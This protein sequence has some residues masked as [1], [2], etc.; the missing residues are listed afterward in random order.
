MII[1]FSITPYQYTYLNFLNGKTETR[2]KKFENDYWG[3]SIKE[4]IKY[5]NFE[6]DKITYLSTCGVNP[7]VA[8]NYF[9]KKGYFNLEFLSPEESD[10]IIMTNRVTKKK[11]ILKN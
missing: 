11:M 10:Y 9:E 1:F 8:K 4:L 2:Y 7:E 5:T 3:S 6:K